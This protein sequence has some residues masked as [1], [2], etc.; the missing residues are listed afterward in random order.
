[1]RSER[2]GGDRPRQVNIRDPHVLEFRGRK[3]R[4]THPREQLQQFVQYG[5]A[6]RPRIHVVEKRAIHHESIGPTADR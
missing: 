4:G 1:M 6:Y 2:G 3:T 5:S